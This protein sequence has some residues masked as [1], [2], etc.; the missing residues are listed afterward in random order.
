MIF[1]QIILNRKTYVNTYKVVLKKP[2][3]FLQYCATN[4]LHTRKLSS[5]INAKKNNRLSLT[6]SSRVPQL[7]LM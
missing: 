3:K 2:D 7:Q 1:H 5:L 6:D 4:S